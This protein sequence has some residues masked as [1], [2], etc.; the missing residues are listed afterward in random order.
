MKNKFHLILAFFVVSLTFSQNEPKAEKLVGEVLE[1]IKNYENISVKFSYNLENQATNTSE[2]TN[3]E[4]Y[5]NGEKYRME[6]DGNIIIYDGQKLYTV[7][8]TDEEVKISSVDEEDN[9]ISPSKMLTFFEEGYNYKWDIEQ[10][11]KGRIIQYIKLI[12]IDTNADYKNVLLG[13]DKY[14]KNISNVIYTMNNGTRTEIKIYSFKT[15]QPLSENLF[16]FDKSKYL[17]YYFDEQ[18]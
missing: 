15:D 11:Q 6:L 16:K 4:V 14:T 13:T 12:P 7:N 3:G 17:D 1:Q 8:N 9:T 10:N 2:E 18:D 5:I